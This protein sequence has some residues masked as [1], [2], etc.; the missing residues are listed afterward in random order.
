MIISSMMTRNLIL[1]TGQR[2]RTD[3]TFVVLT[4]AGTIICASAEP[5]LKVMKEVRGA[6]MRA[7][8]SSI[9]GRLRAH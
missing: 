3:I 2:I 1:S 5:V 9:I 8:G 7:V 4:L 6:Y